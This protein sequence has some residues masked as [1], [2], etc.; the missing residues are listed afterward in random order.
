MQLDSRLF[1][2][3]GRY[4]FRSPPPG[5]NKPANH[6]AEPVDLLENSRAAVDKPRPEGWRS[7]LMK[8]GGGALMVATTLVGALTGAGVA[9]N[10]EVLREAYLQEQVVF[11]FESPKK[12]PAPTPPPKSVALKPVDTDIEG[13]Q[14][15]IDLRLEEHGL[16]ATLAQDKSQAAFNHLRKTERVQVAL[17]AQLRQA[18][19]EINESL[20]AVRVPEGETLLRARVPFPSGDGSLVQ[21]LGLD[22]PVGLKKLATEDLP[23]VLTYQVDPIETGFS[24]SLRTVEPDKADLPVGVEKGLHLGSVRADVTQRPDG[25]IPVSG[26]V[27]LSLDDGEATRRALQAETDPDVRNALMSRLEQI[28]RLQDMSKEQNLQPL[29]D[30]IASNRVVTFQGHLQTRGAQVGTGDLHAWLTPDRDADQRADISLTGE[31]EIPALERDV[32]IVAAEITHSELPEGLGFIE[33]YFQGK[34]ARTVESAALKALPGV[35]KTLRPTIKGVVQE[36]YQSELTRLESQFDGMLDKTLDAVEVSGSEL[37]LDLENLEL[38]DKSGGLRLGI[39]SELPLSETLLPKVTFGKPPL[40][41][42]TPL[43]VRV[44]STTSSQTKRPALILPE[45]TLNQ[46]VSELLQK[47]E[48]QETFQEMTRSARENLEQQARRIPG[49]RGTVGIDLELPFPSHRSVESPLGPLP[50]LSRKTVPLSVNYHIEDFGL[51]VNLELKPLV[52]KNA[53][54]PEEAMVDG[55]FLGAVRV[56]SSPMTTQIFG[57]F[58]IEKGTTGGGAPW[59]E[60]ALDEALDSQHFEFGSQVSAGETDTVFYIWAVPDHNGDGRADVAVSHRSRKN[61]TEAL[62]IDI[63]DVRRRGDTDSTSSLGDKLNHL[64]GKVVV[65]QVSSSSDQMTEAMGSVLAREAASSLQDGSQRVAQ[66]IDEQLK[67]FYSRVS[68]L[69]IPMPGELNTD[70]DVSLHLGQV[71][72]SEDRL[73]TEYS[74]PNIDRLLKGKEV[75]VVGQGMRPGEFQAHLPGEALNSLLADRAQGGTIDWNHIL[76]QAAKKSLLIRK[77]EMARDAQGQNISPTIKTIDGKPT[78]TMPI[79]G[80]T[81]GVIFGSRLDTE[82]RMPLEFELNDGALLVKTG[83]VTFKSRRRGNPKVLDILPTRILS[84]VVTRGLTS[85]LG[86]DA[87]EEAIRKADLKTDLSDIGMEWTRVNVSGVEGQPPDFDVSVRLGKR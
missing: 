37:G 60:T 41:S 21:V 5:E 23:L 66:G 33:S 31:L 24:V 70:T 13:I 44:D 49:P 3:P 53:V 19:S 54:R 67:G 76:R 11:P 1:R 14:E 46:F 50:V 56:K 12:T 62:R 61:G 65:D 77:L 20:S 28:E 39:A 9:T 6:Q 85:L 68:R 7:T 10:A 4:T 38:S 58:E 63:Q 30:F 42:V 27:Q 82:V 18:E 71:K 48:V 16:E 47:P 40:D 43:A 57:D 78:L 81:I 64:V 59:A 29:M 87:V 86:P 8:W 52:P 55:V 84:G 69:D 74:N 51:D 25:Q 83:K 80:R 15:H 17:A 34:L 75:R 35:V 79:D 36:K 72:V 2:T 22:I 45:N 32:E 73:I 26:R